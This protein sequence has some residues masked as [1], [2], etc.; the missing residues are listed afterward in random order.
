[1]GSEWQMSTLAEAGVELIDCLHKTPTA[2]D[3][4]YPY[5][6]IP[7][8][9][10][11]RID[12]TSARR[13]S[14]EDYV[15]WTHKAKPTATD[16]ILSRRCNPGETA[17]I[18]EGLDCALGQ[19]LVL[20]R[21]NED[22]VAPKF[23][24]WLTRG[25][26]WW[27]QVQRHLNVGAVFDSLKCADVPKFELSIPPLPE[28]RAIAHILS[29]LDDKIELNR[30]VN[31][32]LEQMARALF[33]SWFIDFD[34]VH[35]KAAGQTPAGLDP[36]L[37]THF[38]D[39]FQDSPLGPIPAGWEV[40]PLTD[41]FEVNPRRTLTKGNIA[42]Y[43]DMKSMPTDLPRALDC[44]DREFK[45]GTK[46]I[47]GDTLVARI[48]PCLENGKTA[49]VDF[50]DRDDV[51]AWGSTEFIVLRPKSPLPTIYGYYLAR[52]EPFRNHAIVNMTGSSG[53]Q[54]VP[55][56]SLENLLVCIPPSLIT[57]QFG[58][59]ASQCVQQMRENDQESK[60]LATT[61]DTLLPKLLSGE[62]R[63]PE[64][65]KRMETVV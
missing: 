40:S 8:M 11:G 3:Y 21:S 45:S 48:T 54:R 27:E 2:Q 17:V 55:A 20:L 49:Y 22:R 61:R 41:V 19:N 4:G 18:E 26:A 64:A 38:P 31:A 30:Q 39:T 50:L 16:V 42:P 46:F 23:L 28:Q 60:L 44:R 15:E 35:A 9:R 24:R 59:F 56:E 65:M 6:A 52:S 5:I 13:I 62:L 7:Q 34:P 51:V 32:T 12:T 53:R 43:L 58:Q 63:V 57:D 1:M 37:L 33:K 47:N 29:T 14:Q 36:A 10:D 25:P